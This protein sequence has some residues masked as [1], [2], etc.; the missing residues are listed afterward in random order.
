MTAS[1]KTAQKEVERLKSRLEMSGHLECF[2]L[3][4]NK[5]PFG[6]MRGDIFALQVSIDPEMI[7]YGMWSTQRDPM[8]VSL[9]VRYLCEELSQQAQQLIFKELAQDGVFR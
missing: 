8:N 9:H 4:I 5:M 6:R 2:R 3:H 1:L 7:R